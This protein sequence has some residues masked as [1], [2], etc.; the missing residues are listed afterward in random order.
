MFS[1]SNLYAEKIFAEHPLDLWALDE[2]VGYVELLSGTNTDLSGYT[3]SCKKASDGTAFTGTFLVTEET[4][5][6]GIKPKDAPAYKI[7]FSPTATVPQGGIDLVIE[8][9]SPASALSVPSNAKGF[10][11]STSTYFTPEVSSVQFG[12]YGTSSYN[13]GDVLPVRSLVWEPLSSTFLKSSA[14]TNKKIM[15]RVAFRLE[16]SQ[17]IDMWI[18]SISAGIESEEFSGTDNGIVPQATTLSINGVDTSISYYPAETYGLSTSN[19]YY[20]IENG[21]PLAKNTSI[22]LVFGASNSTVIK[23]SSDGKPSLIIPGYNFLNESGINFIRTFECWIR[24]NS[25]SVIPKR[26]FGPTASTDGLYAHG[27]LLTLKVGNNLVSHYVGEWQRPMLVQVVIQ[28]TIISL[29]VNGETV[30]S[31]SVQLSQESLAPAT[32]DFIGFYAHADVPS[33]EIDCIA[34]Y[35]YAV[36]DQMAKRRFIY[37]QAVDLPETINTA[38]GGS[39]VVADG[40]TS[41][42]D[43]LYSFPNNSKWSSGILDNL[44]TDGYKLELPGYSLPEVFLNNIITRS[45]WYEANHINGTSVLSLPHRKTFTSRTSALSSTDQVYIAFDKLSKVSYSKV[46][47]VYGVF[48][49]PVDQLEQET[50]MRL[51]NTLTKDYLD[52]Q[53]HTNMTIHY[54]FNGWL[55]NSHEI[56]NNEIFSVGVNFSKMSEIYPTMSN[57]FS[58]IGSIKMYLGGAPGTQSFG[59]EIAEAGILSV[60][61]IAAISD[62]SNNPL[63]SP[64]YGEP[65]LMSKKIFGLV[66]LDILGVFSLDIQSSGTWQDVVPMSVLSKDL[67]DGSKGLS[68]FQVNLD[69]PE[70]KI[71]SSGNYDTSDAIAKMYVSFQH[72]TSGAMLTSNKTKVSLSSTKEVS[73]LT[74]WENDSYEVVDGTIVRL[75]DGVSPSEIVAILSLEI[76][77]D[78]INAN[79]IAIRSIGLASLYLDSTSLREIGSKYGTKF[80][81]FKEVE[82][83]VY[84]STPECS[85][86]S[87]R[88]STPYMYLTGRTGFKLAGQ[89]D[90][91]THRGVAVHV[92]QTSV[93]LFYVASITLSMVSQSSE[94]PAGTNR[95]FEIEGKRLA[96]SASGEIVPVATY[97]RFSTKRS[98][99]S[100][101][102]ATII[103]QIKNEDGTFSDY[104]KVSFYMNGKQVY[105]PEISSNEWSTLS[106]AFDEVLD[107]SN[108]TGKIEFLGD[109]LFNN[110]SVYRMPESLS[111]IT[112]VTNPWN[113]TKYQIGT[114][115]NV[116]DADGFE[117]PTNDPADDKSW[118]ATYA[119]VEQTKSKIDQVDIYKSYT[120]TNR[121]VADTYES[122]ADLRFVAEKCEYSIVNNINWKTVIKKPV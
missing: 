9:E 29:I 66:G 92:N 106:I 114:W 49:K 117:V 116:L 47:G 97:L 20:I 4:N 113:E 46:G 33:I 65:I 119:T 80:H 35:P 43:K 75:P 83:D 105:R 78:G 56:S 109:M 77:V 63:I 122:V 57:F 76:S 98:L 23:P 39:T 108:I 115:E 68:F 74:S 79:P 40:V 12:Y 72:T 102:R 91:V 52:I 45:S 38:F 21:V 41:N 89:I 93:N 120:G 81:P 88:G 59:G 36:P 58:S 96:L 37:G 11:L 99:I 18:N 13:Y 60:S 42:Y 24:I 30:A 10:S 84:V 48:K 110:V 31:M 14:V 25:N 95:I 82:E 112:L 118:F 16:Y 55:F 61:D 26:I 87:Y 111:N 51:E 28:P 8:M 85:F 5:P 50:L 121:I 53:I 86:I 19:G 3:L 107:M 69:Y 1:P 27:P 44:S 90:N 71:F 103:C 70:H 17:P 22:P 67:V 104:N 34:I 62:M 7:R 2:S 54:V 73:P 15:M 6:E 101:T 94:F 32:E 100:N 64:E